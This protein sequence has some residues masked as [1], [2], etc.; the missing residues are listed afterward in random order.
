MNHIERC[1]DLLNEADVPSA[2]REIEL[3]RK[4]AA[5]A[6]Y[7]ELDTFV[8]LSYETGAPHTPLGAAILSCYEDELDRRSV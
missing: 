7:E 5:R 3:A 1:L 2:R 8:R 4:D 6:T